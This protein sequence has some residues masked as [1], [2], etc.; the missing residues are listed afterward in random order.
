MTM[1]HPEWHFQV[2]TAP[3]IHLRVVRAYLP[4]IVTFN[5]KKT[6]CHRRGPAKQQHVTRL[7]GFSH[8][9]EKCLAYLVGA[10]GEPRRACSAS[11]TATHVKCPL[12]VNPPTCNTTLC[13]CF[14][15]NNEVYLFTSVGLSKHWFLSAYN[16]WSYKSS[17][18]EVNICFVQSTKILAMLPS[19]VHLI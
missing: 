4:E 12:H 6:T 17:F 1:T 10:T 7:V 13:S 3:D 2:L 9:I 14:Q 18:V 15:P 8:Y 16:I 5:C 19:Q 11:G